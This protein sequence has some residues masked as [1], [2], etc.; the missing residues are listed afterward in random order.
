MLGRCL[1]RELDVASTLVAPSR[2]VCVGRWVG[3]SLHSVCSSWWMKG[4]PITFCPGRHDN[5]LHLYAERWQ[6]TP[7][8]AL[9]LHPSFLSSPHCASLTLF[10]ILFYS[11]PEPS[12][13]VAASLDPHPPFTLIIFPLFICLY[14]YFYPSLCSKPS[15]SP[16][17][18]LSFSSIQISSHLL[19]SVRPLLILPLLLL[20]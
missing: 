11:S 10:H 20:L 7:R 15:F 18:Y 12:I 3:L 14:Y 2:E 13:S 5:T 9:F 16:T 1:L 17:C 19:P 6:W 4:P 8:F